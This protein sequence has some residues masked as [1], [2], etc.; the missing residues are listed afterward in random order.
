MV[1]NIKF[2]LEM[3]SNV[4]VR[5]LEELQENFD[6]NKIINYFIDGTIKMAEC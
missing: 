6:F 1:R 2:P 4:E 5:N 3:K